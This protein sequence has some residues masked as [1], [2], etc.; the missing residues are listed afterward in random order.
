[1]FG[2]NL[3]NIKVQLIPFM[4]FLKFTKVIHTQLCVWTV[5]NF[6]SSSSLLLYVELKLSTPKNIWNHS[7]ENEKRKN[8]YQY[9]E[10]WNDQ[11]KIINQ[12]K[13]ENE[14]EK[15]QLIG[16]VWNDKGNN[17]GLIH[18]LVFRCLTVT[19]SKSH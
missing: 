13:Y 17:E 19:Q 14:R 4:F 1:M 5:N 7:R 3:K 12:N 2:S 18:L 11:T 9:I 16:V 10:L 6:L 8:I 15:N